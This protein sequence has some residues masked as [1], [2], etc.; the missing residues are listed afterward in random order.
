M[1]LYVYH[2]KMFEQPNSIS[3]EPWLWAR[4]DETIKLLDQIDSWTTPENWTKPETD[5]ETQ[6][7]TINIPKIDIKN[8]RIEMKKELAQLDREKEKEIGLVIAES[9]MDMSNIGDINNEPMFA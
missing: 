9:R 6:V 5:T 2:L 4:F 8:L 7:Q 3:D 1:S